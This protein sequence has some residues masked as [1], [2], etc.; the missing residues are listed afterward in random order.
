MEVERVQDGPLK[1][2]EITRFLE[3][4]K[5]S[6]K[7]IDNILTDKKEPVFQQRTLIDI[8]SESELRKNATKQQLEIEEIEQV[9][10]SQIM[11]DQED[12]DAAAQKVEEQKE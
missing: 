2:S 6:Y 7:A 3:A 4:S 8:A 1:K 10:Q 12:L 11:S 5:T 9:D